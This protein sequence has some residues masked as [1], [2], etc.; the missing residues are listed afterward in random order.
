MFIVYTW[1]KERQK[2][3]QKETERQKEIEKGHRISRE[4]TVKK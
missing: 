1:Q 3:R 2:E 4:K